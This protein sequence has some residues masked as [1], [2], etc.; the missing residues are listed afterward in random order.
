MKTKLYRYSNK[1]VKEYKAE[2]NSFG[3]NHFTQNDKKVSTLPRLFFYVNNSKVEHRFKNKNKYVAIV[4]SNKL[5]N[6]T[7]NKLKIVFNN[8]DE[9]LRKLKRQGYLGVV[10]TVHSLQIANIFQS[11]KV[12]R[13]Y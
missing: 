6:I 4:D 13:I 7:E 1:T 2:I 9:L 8:I 12:K 5:Y 11:I 3:F 10:Y